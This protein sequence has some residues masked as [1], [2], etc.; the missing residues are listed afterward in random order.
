[1]SQSSKCQRCQL[2][3]LG[4]VFTLRLDADP[5]RPD[6]L[7]V[8]LCTSC[9]ESM[10]RWLTRRN[11]QSEGF[12]TGATAPDQEPRFWKGQ[13]GRRGHYA[14]DLERFESSSRRGLFLSI[15]LSAVAIV[16]AASLVAFSVF[17]AAPEMARHPLDISAPDEP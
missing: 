1:M 6:A 2:P 14:G 10:S 5:P 3:I 8:S 16:V 15:V 9:V 11:R 17:K 4:G 12:E 7:E 13:S